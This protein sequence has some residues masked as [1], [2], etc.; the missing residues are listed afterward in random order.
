MVLNI[1]KPADK[2]LLRQLR[3]LLLHLLVEISVRSCSLQPPGGG[4]ARK[5]RLSHFL[6]TQTNRNKKLKK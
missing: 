2:V 5:I 1:H 4:L 3:L 6:Q